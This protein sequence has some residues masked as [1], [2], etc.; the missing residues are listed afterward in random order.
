MVIDGNIFMG[1][2]EACITIHGRIE[3]EFQHRKLKNQ[4]KPP[5]Y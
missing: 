2:C 3:N 1:L 4:Q 5:K